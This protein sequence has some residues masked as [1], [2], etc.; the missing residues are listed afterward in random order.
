MEEKDLQAGNLTTP[1][2]T[3]IPESPSTEEP[4]PAANIQAAEAPVSEPVQPTGPNARERLRGAVLDQGPVKT[5][6]FMRRAGIFDDYEITNAKEMAFFMRVFAASALLHLLIFAVAMQLPV[7][8]QTTCESTEFT[9]RLCDTMYVASLFSSAGAPDYVD[10]PYDQSAVLGG[11]DVTFIATDAFTYPEGYWAL[12]DELEGKLPDTSVQD[13]G[14]FFGDVNGTNTSSAP[15]IDLTKPPALPNQNPNAVAGG[16]IDSPFSASPNPVPPLSRNGGRRVTESK[17]P[18]VNPTTEGEQANANSNTPPNPNKP[19]GNQVAN[20]TVPPANPDIVTYNGAGKDKVTVNKR[21]LIDFAGDLAG[22]LKDNQVNLQAPFTV[23]VEGAL[24][25]DGKFD[26]STWKFT[27][28]DG[29]PK[30]VDVAKAAI[31][32]VSKSGWLGY[33][34]VLGNKKLSF[35][36]QQDQ[37]KIFVTI[38]SEVDT[39]EKARTLASGL[40][41]LIFGGKIINKG[42]DEGVLLDSATVTNQGKTFILNFSLG[43]DIAQPMI[44]RKLADAGIKPSSETL[45]ANKVST[46]VK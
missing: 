11:G 44:Q 1:P 24:D 16:A 45:S 33:L 26:E 34:K 4:T 19:N 22:K 31:Q 39:E 41:A 13:P 43:Q 20:N 7:V 9:Q 21:V 17:V 3:D 35:T 23:A 25:A 30:M 6:S 2:P 40:N 15:S 18:A 42:T 36:L 5:S 29:D 28:L 46:T 12:Q 8:V 32:A 37:D 27:Q 38:N 10:E 14:S